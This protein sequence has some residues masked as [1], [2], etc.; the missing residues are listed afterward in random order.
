MATI[1]DEL[2]TR[3]R[4]ALDHAS[5][6]KAHKSLDGLKR[7]AGQ[8]MRDF[9]VVGTALTGAVAIGGGKILAVGAEFESLKAQL[10]TV[11]GGSEQANKAFDMIRR[12]AK[13][14]PF[15]VQ[16]VTEAYIRLKGS[17]IEP[18]EERMRSFGNTASSMGKGIMDFVEAATDAS[19][20]EFERLKS[21]NIKARTEGDKIA[22]TF[23]GQ[24]TRVKNSAADIIKFLDS[25]GNT[26]FG[27][28]MAEQM[29]TARGQ[30]SNL[31]D[32]ISQ[33]FDEIANAGPLEEFKGL[34][35]DLTGKVGGGSGS[36]AQ[37]IGK[38]LTEAIKA[39]RDVVRD[40][41]TERVAE[42]F[43][44]MAR[45]VKVLVDAVGVVVRA[46][47]DV[48]DKVG[49][50]GNAIK[51][52]L[53]LLVTMRL[54]LTGAA[55]GW[56][57]LV[58][59]MVAAIPIAIEVG[60]RIGDVLTRLDDIDR[61]ATSLGKPSHGTGGRTGLRGSEF[62]DEQGKA[63]VAQ[64]SAEIEAAEK[65]AGAGGTL[66]DAF[67][68]GGAGGAIDF[69]LQ[70]DKDV[71]RIERLEA[72]RDQLR[73]EARDRAAAR[74][75]TADIAVETLGK[76]AGI[77]AAAGAKAGEA[78]MVAFGRSQDTA[79]FKALRKLKKSKGL[80]PSEQARLN[81]LS[82]K[83]D[84]SSAGAPKA[85]KEDQTAF[86]Q[87]LEAEIDRQVTE[88]EEDAGRRALLGGKTVGE[89]NR[90]AKTA[91]KKTREALRRQLDRGESI[92]APDLQA[93]LRQAGLTDTSRNVTPPVISIQITKIDLKQDINA[94]I[95]V[96]GSFNAGPRE[97]GQVVSREVR[98]VLGNE[99]KLAIDSVLPKQAR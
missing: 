61:K 68:T 18:T 7:A 52:L 74:Q 38:A 21:F 47:Q 3:V 36:L 33:F 84:I 41:K 60:N 9:A 6:A 80:K 24:T 97:F 79:E 71:A 34:V 63:E 46:F 10:K 65:R 70:A 85:K 88:A 96:S 99:V 40:L 58:A 4:Y 35:A 43:A 45:A 50:T 64:V 89:A 57:L 98:R 66:G 53:P 28:A 54:G 22:F 13:E 95:T 91:G 78:S 17:G 31:K 32:T 15:E 25:I 87:K 39:V 23:Q 67:T 72:R 90:L 51:A 56:G 73:Q 37:M 8:V 81:E 86:E 14:T 55:S 12:F 19:V 16:K 94:P 92:L 2:I 62:L 26:T 44:S 69:M 1:V 29:L 76:L 5:E 59:A 48:A 27:G 20:G 49:G 77:Q 82:K 93:L 75:G 83:L 11:A 42:L 30:V